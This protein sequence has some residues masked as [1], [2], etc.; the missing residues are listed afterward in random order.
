MSINEPF[1]SKNS[2]Q[3]QR[4]EFYWRGG[5][6]LKEKEYLVEEYKNALS[7]FKKSIKE[8][9]EIEEELEEASRI[10]Q[11]R[12]GYTDALASFLEQDGLTIKESRLKKDLQLLEEKISSIDKMLSEKR[13]LLNP[14]FA[15]SLTKERAF[16]MIEIQRNQKTLSNLK[17][18][19]ENSVIRNASLLISSEYSQALELD[20][21]IK[22]NQLRETL[23][24]QYVQELKKIVDLDDKKSDMSIKTLEKNP[25]LTDATTLYI[26]RLKQ[27]IIVEHKVKNFVKKNNAHLKSLDSIKENLRNSMISL[28]ISTEEFDDNPPS[29][30]ESTLKDSLVQI[31]NKEQDLIQTMRDL[32]D[33]ETKRRKDESSRKTMEEKKRRENDKKEAEEKREKERT[34]LLEMYEKRM[35]SK[36]IK[37]NYSATNDSNSNTIIKQSLPKKADN[38]TPQSP[39]SIVNSRK[40]IIKPKVEKKKNEPKDLKEHKPISSS[41]VNKENSNS[42]NNADKKDIT[43]KNNVD[44]KDITKNNIR[45][46][47]NKNESK[48]PIKPKI[49]PEEKKPE[50]PNNEFD[51]PE[52]KKPETPNN[53]FDDPEEKKPETPNN[54]FDDP[55]EKKPE[56]PNNEFD[57][58]EEKKPE[59]PNNEF[60]DPEEKKPE[61]PNNDFDDDFENPKDVPSDDFED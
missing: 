10:L 26:S 36:Q 54:E 21:D 5:N 60:D 31:Q 17:D 33:A 61:T 30:P 23:L 7:D 25:Q 28:G 24:K 32:S 50:T 22:Y 8:K 18:L 55:E 46:S 58:P 20:I 52:E 45:Q 41:Q 47:P 56:T 29:I 48:G 19:K 44:K 34:E 13:M 11:D 43:K 59:T 14:A 3:Y 2:S 1:S 4:S 12:E 9:R 38:E 39:K 37:K 42:K 6:P 49:K 51:D 15:G 16:Y 40:E 35:S 53:E 57:D 27:Q